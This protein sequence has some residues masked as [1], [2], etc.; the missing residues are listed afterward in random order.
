MA[1]GLFAGIRHEEMVRLTWEDIDPRGKTITIRGAAAKLRSRRVIEMAPNLARW[2]KPFELSKPAIVPPNWRRDFDAIKSAAGYTGRFSADEAGTPLKPWTQDLLRHTAI[3]FHFAQWKHEGETAS[4]A[5]N[6]P[7][8]VHRHY[9][10]LVQAS[11]AA[12]FWKLQPD[13]RAKTA[14]T[15]SLQAILHPA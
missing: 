3:S 6:S 4:W 1:I 7:D 14:T 9:R 2:L 11:D 12:S 15:I 5:G 10:A 13:P 8:I